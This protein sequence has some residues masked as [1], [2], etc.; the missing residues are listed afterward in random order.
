LQLGTEICVP[1]RIASATSFMVAE[2][3]R[4]KQYDKPSLGIFVEVAKLRSTEVNKLLRSQSQ[5]LCIYC[6]LSSFDFSS[7]FP[8]EN[9]CLHSAPS[10]T[11]DIHHG[12]IPH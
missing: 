5:S 9:C 1:V 3:F 8:F 12:L 10:A 6:L 11:A 7:Y 4:L 2:Q